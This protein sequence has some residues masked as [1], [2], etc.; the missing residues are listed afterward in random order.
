MKNPINP[1]K[2][3]N[4]KWTAMQPVNKQKHFM[5]TAVE[6]DEEQNVVSC[7][8]QALMDKHESAIDWRDLKDKKKWVQG[9]K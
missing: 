4:S 8:I 5:I 2:L 3:L 9:W 6:F 1:K 7:T